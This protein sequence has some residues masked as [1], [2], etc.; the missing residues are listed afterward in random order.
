MITFTQ[1]IDKLN[2]DLNNALAADTVIGQYHNNT[3]YLFNIVADDAEYKKA[4]RDGDTV[5]RYFNGIA[6]FNSDLKSG[7]NTE[8]VNAKL[9][10]SVEIVIPGA[11]DTVIPSGE[12][13]AVVFKDTVR[14]IID[15]A[16]TNASGSYLQDDDHNN[17]LVLAI[18]SFANSGSL[19]IRHEAGESFTFN[20]FIEYAIISSGVS[21][22]KIK[23][24]IYNGSGWEQI[25][26]TR[27][28]LVRSTVSEG[29]I[30]GQSEGTSSSKV[31]PQ[32]TQLTIKIVKPHRG[33]ILD[34][35]VAS[36]ISTGELDAHIIQLEIP[37]G[38]E[39][40]TTT[41]KLC[42]FGEG[43]MAGEN[44]LAI[45]VTAV[46]HELLDFFT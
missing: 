13:R 37:T 8:T 25:F 41:E 12:T 16:L 4:T 40:Y 7:Y 34:R 42:I 31:L 10:A 18:Y 20:I 46:F 21:S 3:Q 14:K 43:T 38:T 39:T 24:S 9:T 36:Y 45:P 26:P 27:I 32:A 28:D 19:D 33:D 23:L 29:V 11:A 22:T 44:I 1:L 2:E 35:A 15:N 6:T 30:P 5:T 17:Y